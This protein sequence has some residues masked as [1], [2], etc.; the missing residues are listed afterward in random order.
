MRFL[1]VTK[2]SKEYG[3]S[4]ASP[5]Q[6]LCQSNATTTRVSKKIQSDHADKLDLFI[7]YFRSTWFN[8]YQPKAF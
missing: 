7:K 1:I 8:L 2:P 3:P 6:S 4:H 5:T